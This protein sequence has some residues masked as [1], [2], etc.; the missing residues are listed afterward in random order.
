MN[1]IKKYFFSFFLIISILLIIYVF[2]KSEIYWDGSKRDYYLQYYVFFSL[3]IIFSLITFFLNEKLREYLII[4]VI[5]IIF[6]IYI[7]EIY[8]IFNSKFDKKQKIELLETAQINYEKKTGRK[9]DKRTKYE[10]YN[11]LK[12]IDDTIQVTIPPTSNLKKNFPLFPLSGISNSKTIFCNENGYYV[13]YE[14]DRF[15]FRNPDKEWDRDTI[16]YLL[17]GDSYTHGACVNEPDDIASVL[18]KLSNE[19]VLNLGYSSNGPLIEYAILREYL[20]QNVKKIVWIY[21]ESN[22][23]NDLSREI[24]SETLKKYLNNLNFTQN[25][26]LKQKIIDE[27]LSKNVKISKEKKKNKSIR[28]DLIKFV[29]LEKTIDLFVQPNLPKSDLKKILEL[30][31]DLALK[32]NSELFFVFLPSYNR[33]IDNHFDNKNYD[34]VKKTVNDLDIEFIDIDQEVFKKVKNP[35]KFYPFELQY[36]FNEY[37]YKSVAETIYNF[38]KD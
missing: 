1:S 29:K 3:I 33:Y 17:I 13:F 19:S 12:K 37:G 10:V 16:E 28:Q 32:N 24:Q 26:K 25:L 21:F 36:H 35:L 5:S 20:P 34:F 38:I 6:S 8:L 7:F 22:D 11:E 4:S 30:V 23:L 2:Y 31:K 27:I 18:R 15:G 14:S 9:Y